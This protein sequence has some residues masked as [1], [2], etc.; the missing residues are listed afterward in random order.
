MCVCVCTRLSC[1]HVP[2]FVCS[3]QI[4]VRSYP[5]FCALTRRKKTTCCFAEQILEDEP[6]R[7]FQNSENPDIYIIVCKSEV[8]EQKLISIFFSLG[9]KIKKEFPY[10]F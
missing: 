8:H 5:K 6:V 10:Q 7:G 9:A 2:A 4:F 3:S 1:V